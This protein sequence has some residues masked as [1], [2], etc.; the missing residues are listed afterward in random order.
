MS[1]EEGLEG[2]VLRG[3]Y[4][5]DTE[6]SVGQSALGTRQFVGTDLSSGT[7]VAVRMTELARL[8]DLGV[9]AASEADALGLFERQCETA[10]GLNHPTI[11]TVLDYGDVTIS[12][13]RIVYAVAEPLE[14]GSL[15]EYLDRGRRLTPSQA[16]VVALDVCRALD[17]AARQGI[18]HGDIR[19]SR[20]VFGLDR[21]VRVVGFGAPHRTVDSM[22]IDQAVYAAPELETGME[23]TATSDV[24]SLA[25]TLVEAMTGTVP[26]S[27]DSV[28]GAFAA[29]SGRLLPVNADFGPLASVLERAARPDPGERF[30]PREAGQSL[31]RVAEQLPKPTPIEIVGTGLFDSAVAATDPS[32]PLAA[33]SPPRSTK[34]APPPVEFSPPRAEPGAP[35]LIRTTPGGDHVDPTLGGGGSVARDDNPTGPI[36][37][38]MDPT[39]PVVLDVDELHA[40]SAE[41][42]TMQ[43]AAPKSRRWGFR[44]AVVVLVLAVLGGGGV[45]A[46]NTVLNPANPV[47]DLTGTTEGEARNQVSR[48]GWKVVVLRERSDAVDEGEVI[49]T[50]PVS[51]SSLKKR[52]TLTVYV[53]EGPPLVTLTDVA[54][55]AEQE[56]KSTLESLGLQVAVVQGNDEV[57]PVGSVISWTVPAQPSLAAGDTLVKGSTV[58]LVVS[59][60]PAKRDVPNL[61]GLT[62]EAAKAKLTELG[63]VLV[64][65]GKYPHPTVPTGGVGIQEPLPGTKVDRGASVGVKISSGQRRVQVPFIYNQDLA[66]VQRRLGERFLII[67]TI[68]GNQSGKLKKATIGGNQIKYKQWVLGGQVVDLVFG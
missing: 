28:Q 66:T 18:V 8:V 9:G 5:L 54:G 14:G 32:R 55:L 68:T 57:V 62:L 50:D 67:G 64:D 35:I 61:S 39:G 63:L 41:D 21:R 19:P 4:Q 56:A 40:L 2:T 36:Q 25:L 29:R 27:S 22:G 26:F 37:L 17:T 58:N 12:G 11:E 7:R 46:Y 47:P 3:R 16:L 38:G 10:M 1:G 42:P 34:P 15:Q 44:V 43:A 49:R 6:R 52:S 48:F 60:G 20:L 31:V 53:S 30:S 45:V 23:R 24:Y 59:I 33:G 51:G 13:R 65:N